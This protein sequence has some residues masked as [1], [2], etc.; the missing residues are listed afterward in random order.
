MAPK[1]FIITLS[2]LPDTGLLIYLTTV[3]ATAPTFVPTSIDYYNYPWHDPSNPNSP[4]ADGL[5]Q[6][7]LTYLTMT[8]YANPPVPVGMA[9]SGAFVET[10]QGA[11]ACMNARLFWNSWLLPLLQEINQATQ[12]VPTAPY[13]EDATSSGWLVSVAPRYNFG[14]NPNHPSYGDSYF[15]WTA[16][17]GN[18]WEWAGGT[19]TSEKT[20]YVSNYTVKA[21]ETCKCFLRIRSPLQFSGSQI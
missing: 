1:V 21:S 20:I 9:Y 18:S 13:L 11:L 5:D 17:G 4:V 3:N 8:D 10:G 14:S 7:A 15:G 16:Y 19:L 12:L 6:N 2:L